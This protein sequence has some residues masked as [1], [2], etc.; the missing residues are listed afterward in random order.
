M[1]H[2]LN[3]PGAELK[4]ARRVHQAQVLQL[5]AQ[6][7]LLLVADRIVLKGSLS[8]Q[9]HKFIAVKHNVINSGNVH[10]F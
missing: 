2:M 4:R 5:K 9:C 10:K 7:L 1:A 3:S 8:I 6:S